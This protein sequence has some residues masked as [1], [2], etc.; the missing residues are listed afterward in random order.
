MKTQSGFTLI[1][2]VAVIIIL[3][4]MAATAMPRFVNMSGDARLSSLQGM[5]AAAVSARTLV[6]SKWVVAN[7]AHQN[8]VDMGGG[9]L[10]STISFTNGPSSLDILGIPALDQTGNSNHGIWFALDNPSGFLSQL[11]AGGATT[12]GGFSGVAVWPAGV[13]IS[14][15]CFMFYDTSGLVTVSNLH[16][17]QPTGTGCL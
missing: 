5:A 15:D 16:D 6:K 9:Y 7:S 13:A 4:I 1:E 2:M 8:T 14:Q 10:V 11:V 3:A 17:T 12:P